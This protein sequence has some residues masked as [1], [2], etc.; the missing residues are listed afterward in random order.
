MFYQYVV[1]AV[2]DTQLNNKLQI[3]TPPCAPPPPRASLTHYAYEIIMEVAHDP[4]DGH[5]K[6]HRVT[7]HKGTKTQLTS[8]PE[9]GGDL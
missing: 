4:L 9:A 8:S 1:H 2:F 7:Q 6:H 3:L 5:L